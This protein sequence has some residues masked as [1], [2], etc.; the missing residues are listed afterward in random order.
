MY[1]KKDNEMHMGAKFDYLLFQS[2]RLLQS[3]EMQH[4]I[5]QCEKERTQILTIMML[6]LENPRLASYMLT[7]N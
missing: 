6:S 2:S 4:L 5:K 1:L 3:S 7:E